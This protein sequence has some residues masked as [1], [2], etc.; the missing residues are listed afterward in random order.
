MAKYVPQQI[1]SGYLSSEV[2]NEE[3]TKIATALENTVSRDGTTPNTMKADLD[4][5]GHALLNVGQSADPNH[6]VSYTEMTNYVDNRASGMVAQRTER[7]TALSGQTLFTLDTI[8]YQPGA[9]NLAVY[10]N[11]A[12]KFAGSDFTETSSTSV[13]FT[14]GL[15]A[16]SVVDFV[17]N[18]Y[19]ATISLSSHSHPWSQITGV[20][21]YTT[22]WP[23]WTEVTG[24]P[25]VFTPDTHVHSAADIT[26]GR[27]ADA[28][29][30]VYV[31]SAAPTGL[32]G[33]DA[34][35]LWFW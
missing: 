29:R 24:K 8:S 19:V 9:G 27:L 34:G 7:E 18:D 11:G 3:L 22:R 16:G 2:V 21:V 17:T 26:S 12:R 23:A 31:Q 35:V 25:T 10:V 1:V 13:T 33:A 28:R 15:T 14:S 32:T 6:V 20:P 4:L 30:G 5:N